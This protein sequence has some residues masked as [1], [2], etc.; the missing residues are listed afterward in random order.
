[1]LDDLITY[2]NSFLGRPYIYGA[3]GPDTFDCSGFICEIL[4][5]VGLVR[6]HEDLTAQGIFDKFKIEQIPI[7][8]ISKGALLFY[9]R[10][11][12]DI[13]HVALA[14]NAYSVIEAGG[15]NTSTDSL[16]KARKLN[17][18]VRQRGINLRS[19]LV[20]IL[21]PPYPWVQS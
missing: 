7:M 12:R 5:S 11:S 19:D 13:S 10:N 16:E 2:A 3:N 9:G 8:S 20:A 6:A 15:G 14:I 21:Q 4:R 1:M 18:C 17:A